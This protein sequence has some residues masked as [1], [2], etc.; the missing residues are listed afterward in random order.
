MAV[1][2][3]EADGAQELHSFLRCDFTV[4]I[5]IQK[6]VLMT[7]NS[8]FLSRNIF[9][10]FP[11]KSQS[12]LHDVVLVGRAGPGDEGERLLVVEDGAQPHLVVHD[13]LQALDALQL[14]P[15]PLAVAQAANYD[16]V[17]NFFIV[18]IC[19]KICGLGCVTRTL[20]HA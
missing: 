5:C 8:S 13:G 20:V 9:Q 12:S 4:E 16:F 18:Q 1:G 14:H 2:R 3:D 17:I 19:K 10:L 15:L 7:E 11:L 6:G